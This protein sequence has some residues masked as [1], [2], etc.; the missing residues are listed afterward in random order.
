MI[1]PVSDLFYTHTLQGRSPYDDV[2]AG[3]GV[4][5]TRQ[6]E[7][8]YDHRGRPV[9]P[10][11]KTINRD[12]IRS[13]NEV[14][15][16]IGVAEPD[17]PKQT[18]ET[19]SQRRHDLYEETV[20]IRIDSVARHC[21]ELVGIVGIAGLRQRILVSFP[22]CLITLSCANGARFIDVI[23]KYHSPICFTMPDAKCPSRRKFSL[24]C[25]WLSQQTGWIEPSSACG[26][27]IA[28]LP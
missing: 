1:Y 17:V 28:K 16:V 14:M 25:P 9:N 2:V 5:D 24:A 21:M 10:T 8:T 11:S 19:E 18:S 23:R 7:L 22:S 3:E 6:P 26:L 27:R 13:H 20:G 12:L 4:A 15:V